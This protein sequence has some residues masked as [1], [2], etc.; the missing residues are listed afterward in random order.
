[1]RG[2]LFLLPTL[3]ASPLS[4]QTLWQN[5]TY[6]MTVNQLRSI[7]PAGSRTSYTP[8]EAVI[9]GFPITE[10][11]VGDVHIGIAAGRVTH[12]QIRGHGSLSETCSDAVLDGLSATYGPPVTIAPG[13]G[14]VFQASELSYSWNRNGVKLRYTRYPND[15][16]FSLAA[17]SWLVDYAVVQPVKL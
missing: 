17:P 5:V 2:W 6:G 1:M 12:V 4:A 15:N 11:C 16:I 3:M 14:A 10:K 13:R 8:A 9:R 7:Y